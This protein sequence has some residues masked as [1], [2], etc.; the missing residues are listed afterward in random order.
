MVREA[1]FSKDDAGGFEI[2]EARDSFSDLDDAILD[3]FSLP[4]SGKSTGRRRKTET[5]RPDPRIDPSHS[6]AVDRPAARR[7]QPPTSRE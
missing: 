2:P 4:R 7:R 1:R 6:P 3:D 5:A